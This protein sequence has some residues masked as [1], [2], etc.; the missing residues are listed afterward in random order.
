MTFEH[1]QNRVSIHA[2]LVAVTPIFVGARADSFKPGAI[3]GACVKDIYGIP[4][5]PGSSLKGA[6][7]AFLSNVLNEP[8]ESKVNADFQKKEQREKYSTPQE[9]AKAVIDT[10]TLVELL[11]GSQRM[12][13]KVKIA[14]A[15][16]KEDR[17]VTEVRNGV[18]I[19]RDTRTAL[20]GA[21]FDT[22]VVPAG[23]EFRFIASAENL[24]TEEAE[25]FGQ[26]MEYF[27]EGNI[28]I[29]GRSRAGLGAVEL[30]DVLVTVYRAVKDGFPTSEEKDCNKDKIGIREAVCLCSQS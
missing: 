28:T 19:D 1:F 2:K 11:F 29:G 6:L 13:G 17:T 10:S 18:A 14:D 25:L 26:L 23:T 30:R 24:T 4:Y 27:A 12:A 22:E 8:I 3:N 21:L 5:I 9:L 16:P 15:M 20:G 7:R